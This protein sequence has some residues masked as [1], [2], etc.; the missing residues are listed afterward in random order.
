MHVNQWNPG[1][2]VGDLYIPADLFN[3]VKNFTGTSQT[4]L[5]NQYNN[6]LDAYSKAQVDIFVQRKNALE[7]QAYQVSDAIDPKYM[8]QLCGRTF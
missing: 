3:Q 7:Q 5:V 4:D 6:A 1:G 2:L 8:V